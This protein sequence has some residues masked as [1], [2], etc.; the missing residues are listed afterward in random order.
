[1]LT[2]L[3]RFRRRALHGVILLLL[4][5]LIMTFVAPATA[6][7]L[8]TYFLELNERERGA[9]VVGFIDL[10]TRDASREDEY[11]ACVAEAGPHHLHEELTETVRDD[12]RMLAYDA[13]S[14]LLYTAASICKAGD[15]E[16][17]KPPPELT[18]PQNDTP[19][20]MP[21]DLRSAEVKE[22]KADDRPLFL[23]K[24]ADHSGLAVI[25][26]GVGG[27]LIGLIGGSML[28]RLRRGTAVP[29]QQAS[30]PSAKDQ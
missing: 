19:A 26:G 9:Y 28:S 16:R 18:A 2:D 30:T 1:M 12:P 23:A 14:W 6:I 7:T 5:P 20:V 3:S 29:D 17:P 15:A 11:R 8:E 25:L 13:A 10:F 4:V 22:E 27:A 21:L 24:L